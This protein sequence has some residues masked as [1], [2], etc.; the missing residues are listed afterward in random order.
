MDTPTARSRTGCQR[1]L[2]MQK[3]I[4]IKAV[5]LFC[6]TTALAYGQPHVNSIDLKTNTNELSI[7]DELEIE[8]SIRYK[9]PHTQ[10]RLPHFILDREGHTA[11]LTQSG[12]V[13]ERDGL[14][15]RYRYR[16]RSVGHFHFSPRLVWQHHV[17][18]LKPIRI[19]VH[20]ATLSER[21]PFVWK[22][23]STDGRLI[24]DKA[25][26][27]Q[28]NL[29]ILSLTAAF[30]SDGYTERYNDL[31]QAVPAHSSTSALKENKAKQD[32]NTVLP[33][34]TEVLRIEC[35]PPE[36]AALKPINL[37]EL[38]FDTS[39]VFRD[40]ALSNQMQ[41]GDTAV[42][43]FNTEALPC[44]LALFRYIP[45]KTGTLPLPA[46]TI[47]FSAGK[48]AV[49]TP[50]LYSIEQKKISSD[51]PAY[52]R[53]RFTEPAFT[54]SQ[55]A[56]DIQVKT[57]DEQEKIRMAR[58]VAKCR[59]QEMAA[60]FSPA[61]RKKR[62]A[63]EAALR[64]VHPLP[65]YPRLFALSLAVLSIPLFIGA[66]LCFVHNKKRRMVL[67]FLAASCGAIGSAALFNRIMLA[68]GVC[69]VDNGE[70]AVRRIP[71]KLGSIV[72]KLSAGE[73]VII[74]HKTPKWYY[75]KTA[76][77]ITGWILPQSLMQ[78]CD[79]SL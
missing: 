77:G 18:N 74:L 28:G 21:T 71:E 22:L 75:V 70:C 6:F 48:K 26:L 60:L 17:H 78:Y 45:L 1:L 68:Q 62:Q 27:E 64:I 63:L 31:M 33:L 65:I 59:R 44:V 10:A 56:T 32:S 4:K 11:F 54:E 2:M 57:M 19:T 24:P 15:L 51:T 55:P 37:T 7:E 72:Y 14:Q 79:T 69:I 5:L 23:Y 46:A 39:T 66:G 76:E 49:S 38:P 47:H 16:F 13:P 53:D 3:Y 42:P 30:Y 58:E 9:A 12:I 52:S 50:A 29:Y 73:S 34:P 25:T 61:I 67:L 43:P 8:I 41:S 35:T 40:E 20:Q 36:H